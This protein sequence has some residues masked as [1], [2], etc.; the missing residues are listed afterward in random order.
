MENNKEEKIK[1]SKENFADDLRLWEQSAITLVDIRHKLISS[2]EAI[3]NYLIPTSMFLYTNGGKAEIILNDISYTV[4]RFGVFHAGKGTE[5][6]IYPKCNWLEYYIILYKAGEPPFYKREFIRLLEK[7]NLFNQQYGYSPANPIFFG[8]Q[9]RKM[10]EAWIN[11]CPL[12]LF[13]GKTEFYQLV[14]QI[15]NELLNEKAD[16]FK[17]DVVSMVQRYMDKHFSEAISIGLL[18]DSFGISI[19]QLNRLFKKRFSCSPQAYLKE[20]RLNAVQSYLQNSNVTF[21][22]IANSTG[23]YDEFYMSKEFK[24]R[25]GQTPSDFRQN[26]TW[27]MGNLSM[28][29]I[30]SIPYNEK[31]LVSVSKHNMEGEFSMFKQIKS[32]AVIGVAL[33]LIFLLTACTNVPANTSNQ[34]KEGLITKQ[35]QVIDTEEG[36]RIVSTSMGEVEVP[37]NPKR[38]VVDYVIGDVIALGVLPVGVRSAFGGSAF[39]DVIH[40]ATLIEKWDPEEVMELE[41]DLIISVVKDEFEASSKIAPTVF[42]P[43]TEMSME[44]RVTFL[45]EV[46]NRQTE[47]ESAIREY[48]KKVEESKV[49]LEKQGILDKTIS[50]FF[51]D[52]IDVAVAGDKWGRGG[53]IIYNDLGFRAPDVIQSE[54]IGGDQH[55]NLSLEVL[56]QYVGDYIVFDWDPKLFEQ[57]TIWNSIPAYADGRTIALDFAF[58]Y[59]NDLY[60]QSRQL[61]FIVDNLLSITGE[62]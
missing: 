6:S 7:T 2:E 52:P 20:I 31:S 58:F 43:F 17:P 30:L 45:G 19:S 40:D 54:I 24:K 12:G 55:R 44:E 18:S 37:V 8:G 46:L 53:D 60:S 38:V 42:I 9:F 49:V 11:P 34:D 36:T 4:E 1:F 56:P 3:K 47:A 29:N 32:K 50:I 51:G 13:Y 26:T 21:R 10:Y 14:Y 61:D 57:T 27:T 48:Y 39:G 16:N 23:F 5:L 15:Y 35:E 41:P 22:E 62:D 33:S 25:F 59:Y 28:E